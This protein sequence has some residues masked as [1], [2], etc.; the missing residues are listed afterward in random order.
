MRQTKSAGGVR[1]KRE[2]V[3]EAKAPSAACSEDGTRGRTHKGA[4]EKQQT[5]AQG[6][7]QGQAPHLHSHWMR[8]KALPQFPWLCSDEV[9]SAGEVLR[10]ETSGKRALPP[11]GRESG[12]CFRVPAGSSSLPQTAQRAALQRALTAAELRSSS[13]PAKSASISCA[14][15]AL[16]GAAFSGCWIASA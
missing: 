4:A 2:V 10:V 14:G 9:Q 16:Q 5:T 7:R 13:L 12:G 3:P 6:E 11:T 1:L 8:S 15:E